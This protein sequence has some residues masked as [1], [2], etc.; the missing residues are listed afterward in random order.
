MVQAGQRR[1][2]RDALSACASKPEIPHVQH[3]LRQAFRHF[4]ARQVA[5]VRVAILQRVD[6]GQVFLPNRRSGRFAQLPLDDRAQVRIPKRVEGLGGVP[7]AVAVAVLP[8]QGIPRKQV[9][10]IGHAVAVDI[11]VRVVAQPVAVQVRPLPGVQREPVLRV[12]PAIAVDVGVRA[13]AQPVAVQIRPVFRVVRKEVGRVHEPVPVRVRFRAAL[14]RHLESNE[15]EAEDRVGAAGVR[16]GQAARSP[17]F[18]PPG[19]GT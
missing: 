18:A 4:E 9:V 11:G 8:V 5:N 10:G 19:C 12:G 17:R 15:V 7:H 14:P 13:V 16:G 2:V 3:Q 1:Q 6:P